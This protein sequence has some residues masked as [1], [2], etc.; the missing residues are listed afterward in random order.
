MIDDVFTCSSQVNPTMHNHR[1]IPSLSNVAS[2]EMNINFGECFS[3]SLSVSLCLCLFLCLSVC[4]SVCLFISLSL[5]VSVYFSV[6]LGLCLFLC[7]SFRS[8][9]VYSSL[10]LIPTCR[11]RSPKYSHHFCT[12]IRCLTVASLPRSLHSTTIH[13]LSFHSSVHPSIHSYIST[14]IRP[15]IHLFVRSFICLSFLA[16]IYPSR[17]IILSVICNV[18]LRL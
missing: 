8:G 7:L 16:S 18:F 13:S 12:C 1:Y 14:S 5:C 2:D 10:S 11:S 3:L 4:L 17:I 15:F 9:S 6:S